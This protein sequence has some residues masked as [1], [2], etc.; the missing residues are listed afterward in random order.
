MEISL[1]PKLRISGIS[2]IAP[3]SWKIIGFE[4]Y[5]GKLESN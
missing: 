2:K 3:K 1:A 4:I 5:K